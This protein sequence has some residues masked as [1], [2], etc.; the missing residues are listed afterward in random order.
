[1]GIN[2][3]LDPGGNKTWYNILQKQDAGAFPPTIVALPAH[4]ASFAFL[5]TVITHVAKIVAT[6]GIWILLPVPEHFI[7]TVGVVNHTVR[8]H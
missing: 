7:P 5:S 1:M 4:L 6:P 3:L 8:S 2:S